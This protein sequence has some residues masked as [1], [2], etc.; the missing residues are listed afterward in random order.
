MVLKELILISNESLDNFR[1]H[2]KPLTLETYEKN[3]D[4]E[5]ES[6]AVYPDMHNYYYIAVRL[7]E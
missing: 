5:V 1:I 3:A 6:W 4:R 7:V 2:G